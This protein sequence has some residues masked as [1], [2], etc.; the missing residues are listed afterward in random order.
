MLTEHVAGASSIEDPTAITH[1]GHYS[2]LP[3]TP[4]QYRIID[5]F[6]RYSLFDNARFVYFLPRPNLVDPLA[7][8]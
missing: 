1:L 7:E 3:S 8:A 6:Y 2:V 4:Y 5:S